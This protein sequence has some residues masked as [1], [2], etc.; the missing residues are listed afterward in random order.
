M[1]REA[2]CTAH[3]NGATSAGKLQH[4]TDHLLFRGDYRLR[5]SLKELKQVQASNGALRV[6]WASETATFELGNG[7]ASWA[8]ALN[9]PK[10]VL[11]KLGVKPEHRVSVLAVTDADFLADLARRTADVSQDRAVK[12]SDLIFLQADQAD[13][14]DMLGKLG[15]QINPNGAVW[16]VTPRK[17]PDVADTVVI[18]AGRAAGLVDVKVVRFSDTHTAL[19]FVIPKKLR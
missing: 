14:L 11:D 1:G 9:N 3:Y 6:D 4:E 5:I 2:H 17:R 8:N 16:V 13:D 7:A 19:K 18:A 12:G 10:T 15:R